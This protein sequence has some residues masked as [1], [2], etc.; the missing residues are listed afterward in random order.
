METS[1]KKPGKKPGGLPTI[2]ILVLIAILI[3]LV[4]SFLI[5]ALLNYK[6]VMERSATLSQN[7][8]SIRFVCGKEGTQPIPVQLD[9]L[10]DPQR[11][12]VQ[13][14][15]F[16]SVNAPPE[17]LTNALQ[18]CA[19]REAP[20]PE[21]Q[22]RL[23]SFA[24]FYNKD[25]IPT[26]GYTWKTTEVPVAPIDQNPE[27][28]NPENPENPNGNLLNGSNDYTMQYLVAC[29]EA[30]GLAEDENIKELKALCGNACA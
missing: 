27:A 17:P 5:W 22:D 26:C 30:N 10:D 14:I 20:E 28:Y 23:S 21:L 11:A 6:K 24:K 2:P 29:A 1:E 25:Y 4:I 3:I 18:N 9:P 16:C 12:A 8:Y 19:A 7:P 13:T 15:N